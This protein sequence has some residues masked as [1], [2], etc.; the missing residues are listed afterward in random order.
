MTALTALAQKYALL[1]FA[2]ACGGDSV[3]SV[4]HPVCENQSGEKTV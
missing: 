2:G 1:L 4:H 3:H